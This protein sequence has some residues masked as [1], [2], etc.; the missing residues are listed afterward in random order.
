MSISWFVAI[1]EFHSS[2]F[3]QVCVVLFVKSIQ[4]TFVHGIRSTVAYLTDGCIRLYLKKKTYNWGHDNLIVTSLVASHVNLQR[5]SSLSIGQTKMLPSRIN[6]VPND[7][8]VHDVVYF[9]RDP[10]VY[11]VQLAFRAPRVLLFWIHS[12]RVVTSMF[13]LF[14][15]NSFP[16][17][18]IFIRRQRVHPRTDLLGNRYVHSPTS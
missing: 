6:P 9:S 14:L 15:V 1:S 16:F 10:I 8:S 13:V 5:Y 3:C 12:V 17:E 4:I 7:L 18:A 2:E 11:V